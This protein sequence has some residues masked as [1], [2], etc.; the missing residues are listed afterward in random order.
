MQL[1]DPRTVIVLTGIMSGMMA[2]V[3]N[4]LRRSYPQSIRGLK[5]W[6]LALSILF[7]AGGL[8]A[9][10]GFIPDL[11]S[12]SL[13]N[14]LLFYGLYIAYAGTQLFFGQKPHPTVWLALIAAVVLF[15]AWYT[16]V[17]PS[18]AMRLHSANLI[19]SCLFG[20]HAWLVS[21][22]GTTTFSRRLVFA[23]MVTMTLVP[24]VRLL[25]ASIAPTG[26]DVLSDSPFQLLYVTSFA[27]SV[28]LFSIGAVLMATD[29]LR[30]E[31]EHLATHD[32]L[33]NALN[34]RRMNEHCQQELDRSK[35][36]GRSL[37]VLVMDL[38]HFKAINDT[39]GHQAGDKVLVDFVA[40]VQSLLRQPDR[41]GR[42]GGEEF[43]VLL[44]ETG[45]DDAVAVAERIRQVSAV[46]G[47]G[48]S[49]SVSIG[50]S[51]SL[52]TGDSIEALLAR[53]DAAMYRSKANG[54]NR[55][56]IA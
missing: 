19:I 55:V 54:R 53:A 20:S 50:V 37:A 29:Q 16:Y 5:Q 6:S 1:F 12:L 13:S 2:L 7:L 27:L 45:L 48:P 44:P 43:V 36:S 24:L 15:Q 49:C 11:L 23:V 17:A 28:L 4:S 42:F 41:L 34:R 33:T 21:R 25:T 10:R 26:D 51:E 3:L 18:Y 38:D 32:S 14:F 30:G 39:H 35:R 22:Q 40:K 56:E 47:E 9:G 52:S 31:L 46:A 8:T